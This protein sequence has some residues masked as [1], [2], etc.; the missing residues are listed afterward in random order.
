MRTSLLTSQ[1]QE[2]AMQRNIFTFLATFLEGAATSIAA[3][4]GAWIVV[5]S[6]TAAWQF[7]G[8]VAGGVILHWILPN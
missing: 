8:H 4:L 5:T 7:L 3:Y 1:H 2:V 6:V